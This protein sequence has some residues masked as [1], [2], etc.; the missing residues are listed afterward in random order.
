MI[1]ARASKRAGAYDAL[2]IANKRDSNSCSASMEWE[3]S[4]TEWPRLLKS[5]VA[6]SPSSVELIASR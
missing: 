1:L 6:I 4:V 2:A 3:W 5:N